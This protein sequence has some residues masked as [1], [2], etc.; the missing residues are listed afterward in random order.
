MAGVKTEYEV[1][2]IFIEQLE[3]LGYQYI[4]MANYDDV[5]ANF[6]VQFCKVN[7]KALI[8]AKGVAELSDS[9]FAKIM[10]RPHCTCR[11]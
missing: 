1:E 6:R 11:S 3:G 2:R 5:A 7:A 4:D 10:L 8:E 9:E